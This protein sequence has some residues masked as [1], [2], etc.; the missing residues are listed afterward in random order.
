MGLAQKV[1]QGSVADRNLSPFQ[2]SWDPVAESATL[3]S[4]QTSCNLYR[5]FISLPEIIRSHTIVLTWSQIL[6]T[7]KATIR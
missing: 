2:E 3:D 1:S 5:K 7:P 6:E 4:V